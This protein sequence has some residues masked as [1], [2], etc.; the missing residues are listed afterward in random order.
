MPHVLNAVN[1]NCGFPFKLNCK[2][3][4]FPALS[5]TYG[6]HINSFKR[7]ILTSIL[8]SLHTWGESCWWLTY[9]H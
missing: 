5:R 7:Y 1:V 9:W 2:S 6:L 3:A 4:S 8:R